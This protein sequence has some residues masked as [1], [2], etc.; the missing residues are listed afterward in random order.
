MCASSLFPFFETRRALLRYDRVMYVYSTHLY[1][2]IIQGVSRVMIRPPDQLGQEVPKPHGPD[3]VESV[4]ELGVRNLT[5][6]I[7]PTC[8]DVFKLHGSHQAVL[9]T[10]HHPTQHARDVTRPGSI[11][12]KALKK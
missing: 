3:Q 2:N 5:G 8:E 7:G 9:L 11:R 6:R 12:E 1:R 10:R 4:R